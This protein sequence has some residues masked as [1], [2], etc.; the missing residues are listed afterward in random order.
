MWSISIAGVPWMGQPCSGLRAAARRERAL[1][2]VVVEL[3]VGD[4]A[5]AAVQLVGAG[6]G[7]GE[8]EVFQNWAARVGEARPHAHFLEEVEQQ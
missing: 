3:A 5:G 2:L 7:G 1:V 8:D 6:H 4:Q